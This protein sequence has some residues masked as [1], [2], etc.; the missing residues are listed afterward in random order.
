MSE[1]EKTPE[2]RGEEFLKRRED[3]V[4]W[5]QMKTLVEIR[6]QIEA[7]KSGVKQDENA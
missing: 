5:E 1:E 6:D 3:E 2:E 7:N 4:L